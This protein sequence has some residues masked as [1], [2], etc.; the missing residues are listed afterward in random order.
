MS[1]LRHPIAKL[2]VSIGQFDNRAEELSDLGSLEDLLIFALILPTGAP[3]RWMG[4]VPLDA[5]DTLRGECH[6]LGFFFI[7]RRESRHQPLAVPTAWGTDAHNAK[8]LWR[9]R[10]RG[11]ACRCGYIIVANYIAT[12]CVQRVHVFLSLL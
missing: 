3:D 4:D 7:L 9:R 6:G 10:G 2:L 1:E 8:T 11:G 12:L 5:F